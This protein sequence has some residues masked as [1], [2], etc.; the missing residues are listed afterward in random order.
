MLVIFFG[1]VGVI[2]GYL[3]LGMVVS[4]FFICGIIV[5][6]GVVVN[7]SLI[8]VDFVNCVCKEGMLLMD[9]V[10]SVGI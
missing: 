1:I 2:V 5:L 4:V 9:V 10:I 3:V 7:D 6:F 8:M